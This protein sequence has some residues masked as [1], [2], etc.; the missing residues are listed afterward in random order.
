[1]FHGSYFC[2]LVVGRK[3]RENLDV[4]KISCY[5]TVVVNTFHGDIVYLE[6]PGKGLFDVFWRLP[7][8]YICLH[9]I[10]ENFVQS[11]M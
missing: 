8:T 10:V 6:T 2:V 5:Y 3:N 11:K 1:M 9:G 7:Y 4:V